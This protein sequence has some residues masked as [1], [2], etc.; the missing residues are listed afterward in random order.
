[1]KNRIHPFTTIGALVYLVGV[2]AIVLVPGSA[3]ILVA[4]AYGCALLEFQKYTSRFQ[5][6]MLLLT[7]A[8]LG[9]LLDLDQNS[10]PLMTIALVLAALATFLRQAKMQV[11]TYVNHTWMEPA[12]MVI[13]IG[14]FLLNALRP[15]VEWQAV[16]LPLP[17]L[18]FA[19]G[20]TALY[21]QDGILFRR[22]AS[23]A[24]RVQLGHVAPDFELPDQHGETVRL[25][26]YIGLHPVLL[27]FVRGDWCP[28]CHVLL[29]TYERNREL[30]REKGI[31]VLGIGPDSVDVNKDMVERIGVGYKLLSDEGQHTSQRYG[32][33]YSN[34]ILESGLDYEE[35]I[36]L[37]ASFLV[38]IDGVVRYVSRPDQ[39][40]EFL[41]PALIF[42][43]LDALPTVAEQTWKAA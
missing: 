26:S 35:G 24:Y 29:R 16:L 37:P 2:A 34:P 15:G 21:V 1:M 32:V 9:V 3:S 28:G 38:D 11:F 36:P 19:I 10:F 22:K 7:G 30:F 23:A 43:V 39:V 25:S 8:T 13:A 17:A 33:I 14:S 27:I 40:G 42:G 18:L 5:F 31:H 20:L 6:G 4:V 12:M 41:D